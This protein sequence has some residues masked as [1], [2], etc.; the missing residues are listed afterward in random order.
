MSH[1]HE[2]HGHCHYHQHGCGENANRTLLVTIITIITMVAEVSYGFLTN[3]MALLSDG[4]HMGTHALALG[5]AYIAYMFINKINTKENE[6]AHIVSEKISSFA[7]YTSSLFLLLSAVWIIAESA[8]RFVK[9]LEISFNEAILVAVIGLIVNVACIF[10]MEFKNGGKEDDYNYKA[11]YLHILTD[12]LT[13]VFAIIALL[14]GKYLGWI[15]LD[16]VIGMIGGFVILKWSI[17]LVKNTTTVLL[18]LKLL[19]N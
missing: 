3:S 16:P 4:W 8:V 18:D 6:H 15:L 7:G 2:H 10:V 11:A 19:Q 13:S 12:V 1:H 5:M 14:A 9:P 17:Q